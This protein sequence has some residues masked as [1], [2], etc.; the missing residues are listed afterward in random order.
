[1]Q[2]LVS[3]LTWNR[4]NRGYLPCAMGLLPRLSRDVPDNTIDLIVFELVED[5]IAGNQDVVKVVAARLFVSIL[6]F[7][8][9]DTTHSS[10]VSK[11]SLTVAKSTTHGKPS[12]EDSIRAYERILVFITVFVLRTWLLPNLLSHCSWHTT[13]HN[14]LC[15]INVA[16]GFHNPIVLILITRLVIS[17]KL[18]D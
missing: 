5:S 3:N 14:C 10:Q 1:M 2:D 9:H 13:I 8:C 7:T 17:R 11:L 12:R 18:F 4:V 15:L 6:R 16:S